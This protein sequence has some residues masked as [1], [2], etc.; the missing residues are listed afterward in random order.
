MYKKES[1]I[2]QLSCETLSLFFTEIFITFKY[3]FLFKL[4]VK[5][6][7]WLICRIKEMYRKFPMIQC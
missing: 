5:N 1:T 7:L 6:Q 3:I 4:D 2:L